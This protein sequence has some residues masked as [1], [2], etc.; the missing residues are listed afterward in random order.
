MVPLYK[1]TFI[2]VLIVL[3]QSFTTAKRFPTFWKNVAQSNQYDQ[4]PFRYQTLYFDQKVSHYNFQQ[5]GKIFKQKYLLDT[6]NW[7]KASK[8]PI[9]M[10]CG[11]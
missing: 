3:S 11:N 5:T 10:Y 6:T 2:M 8:G 1:L 7:D 4:A 9:L